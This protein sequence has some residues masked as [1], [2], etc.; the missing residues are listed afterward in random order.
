MIREYKSG[1]LKEIVDIVNEGLLF[2]KGEIIDKI[3]SN[4]ENIIVFEEKGIKGFGYNNI[5]SEETKTLEVVIYVLPKERRKGIG[6]GIYNEL[7]KEIR[8]YNPN[9]L[10]TTFRDDDEG[11]KEFYR[12]IGFKRW[13]ASSEMHYRGGKQSVELKVTTLKQEHIKEYGEI[14]AKCF[15]KIHK[16]NDIHPYDSQLT[17]EYCNYIMSIKDDIHVCLDGEKIVATVYVNKGEI[18]K[19]KVSPAYQGLGYG[20]KITKFA[21]NKALDNGVDK[22]TLCVMKGNTE[23]ENLYKSLGFET[24]QT[25]NV[26]RQFGERLE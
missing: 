5:T 15:Y 23:A 8:R 11:V 3:N 25:L 6:T 20:K 12:K 4:K 18:D 9:L 1:D 22:V 2:E 17:D 19:L 26:Y 14:G 13:Y 21:I 16:D 24:V 7:E 10:R